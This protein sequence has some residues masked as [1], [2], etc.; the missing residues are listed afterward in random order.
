MTVISNF[1]KTWKMFLAMIIKNLAKADLKMAKMLFT[2]E[3][4]SG[5]S[6]PALFQV[7]L[8]I[9]HQDIRWLF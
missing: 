1:M 7:Y 8:D 4:N 6:V 2:D 3:K 9:F 5:T